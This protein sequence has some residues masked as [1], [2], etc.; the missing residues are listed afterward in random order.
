LFYKNIYLNMKYLIT[1][2]QKSN[3]S[4]H[5]ISS[6][7]SDGFLR[8]FEKFNMTMPVLVKILGDTKLPKFSCDDLGDIC[9]KLIVE[10]VIKRKYVTDDYIIN[11]DQDDF[12]SATFF[13][14]EKIN[15]ESTLSGYATPFWDGNC[16]L[17][18]DLD[19]YMYI[20]DDGE[21]TDEEISGEHFQRILTA[22]DFNTL[23]D[24]INWMKNDYF[25]IIID[26]C[27]PIFEKYESD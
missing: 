23:Q 5:I 12:I 9:G 21:Q 20:D 6:F 11:I 27:K 19:Y 2:S 7:K 17:P 18:I 26:F 4:K 1:E 22:K 14:V 13:S 15:R 10:N 24:I 3:L 25:K 8:T 16:F